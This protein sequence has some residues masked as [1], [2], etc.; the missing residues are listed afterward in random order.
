MDHLLSKEKDVRKTRSEKRF[1]FG[2]ERSID[3]S[4]RNVL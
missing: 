4:R 1:L 3:F 2:F